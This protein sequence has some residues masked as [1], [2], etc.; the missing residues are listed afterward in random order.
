[1]GDVG[2]G[3]NLEA[4]GV[5]AFAL[6]PS[7]ET[8]NVQPSP[9]SGARGASLTLTTWTTGNSLTA[10]PASGF[11]S[12]DLRTTRQFNPVRN[13]PHMEQRSPPAPPAI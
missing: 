9:A 12:S 13:S 4:F 2:Q 3:S 1:M 5:T 6:V 10:S 8:T 7:N 11:T